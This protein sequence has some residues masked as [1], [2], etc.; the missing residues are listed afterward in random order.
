M[1]TTTNN[2]LKLQVTPFSAEQTFGFDDRDEAS[3]DEALK[4][5]QTARG[6]SGACITVYRAIRHGKIRGVREIG[7]T[8]GAS[9]RSVQTGPVGVSQPNLIGLPITRKEVV[10]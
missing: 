1:T 6:A 7:S 4:R 8:T 9:L 3:R 2:Y 10:A 5:A